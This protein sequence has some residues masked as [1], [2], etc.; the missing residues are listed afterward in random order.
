MNYASLKEEY[1]ERIVGTACT[2]IVLAGIRESRTGDEYQNAFGQQVSVCI[3][4]IKNSEWND[5]RNII[6][7]SL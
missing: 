3:E 1:G 2:D 4:K 7:R 5:I 6:K